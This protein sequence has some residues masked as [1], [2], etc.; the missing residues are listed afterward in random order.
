MSDFGSVLIL[1]VGS[2]YR[3]TCYVMLCLYYIVL[4]HRRKTMH[5]LMLRSRHEP[6]RREIQLCGP[7]V[8]ILMGRKTHRDSKRAGET[9]RDERVEYRVFKHKHSMECSGR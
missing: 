5:G 4:Y 2:G 7:E 8:H 3:C 9:E 6:R 1:G